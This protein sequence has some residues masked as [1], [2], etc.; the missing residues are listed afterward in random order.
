MSTRCLE[1]APAPRSQSHLGPKPTPQERLPGGDGSSAGWGRGT[2]ASWPGPGCLTPLRCLK[3]KV[4]LRVG[5]MSGGQRRQEVQSLRPQ[6]LVQICEDPTQ[7]QEIVFSTTEKVQMRPGHGSKE[8]DTRACCPGRSGEDPD[9]GPFVPTPRDPLELRPPAL[10]FHGQ[11]APVIP[12]LCFMSQAL[13]SLV[14]PNRF[15]V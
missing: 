13:I 9:R 1:P 10:P 12:A 5:E 11:Q 15:L 4:S 14:V 6:G 3:K 8:L 7:G 2:G